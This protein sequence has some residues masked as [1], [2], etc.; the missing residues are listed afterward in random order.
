MNVII[1]LDNEKVY[2]LIEV[3]NVFLKQKKSI[4]QTLI[5]MLCIY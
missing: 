3:L 2:N 1:L 5:V 4:Y